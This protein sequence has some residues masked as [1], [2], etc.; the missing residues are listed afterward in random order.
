MVLEWRTRLASGSLTGT[1]CCINCF[2]PK[3]QTERH[4]DTATFFPTVIPFPE[5]KLEDFLQQT[6]TDIV[7][8]VSAPPKNTLPTLKIGQE[9]QNALLEL[10]TILKRI[11][12][13]SKSSTPEPLQNSPAKL[14]R[15]EE[16][17]SGPGDISTGFLRVE[18]PKQSSSKNSPTIQASPLKTKTKNPPTYNKNPLLD[19]TNT[20]K[21]QAKTTTTAQKQCLT[22]T[23]L[24]KRFN[25]F[26][27]PLR[28]TGDKR[29]QSVATNYIVAQHLF[30][31]SKNLSCIIFT[32]QKAKNRPWILCS[33]VNLATNA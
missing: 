33:M 32:I 13:L 6:A 2:F 3:T 15:V 28:F 9:H 12:P 5:I 31:T 30:Q 14:P 25:P 21:N 18:N 4:V 22:V 10:A 17:S 27:Y 20:V 29:Y 8:I 24:Q 19:I 1:F 11:E 16:W 7:T 26:Q 23:R